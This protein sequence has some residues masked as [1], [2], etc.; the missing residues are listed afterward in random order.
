M[1]NNYINR[2]LSWLEF[3]RRVLF[4]AYNH[5]NPLMERL[6]FLGISGSNLD[7]FFMV[8]VAGLKGQVDGDIYIQ[9]I[10]GMIPAGA[11]AWAGELNRDIS[12][13]LDTEG[14]YVYQCDPH[15]MMAMIGVIQV[16]EA[17]NMNQIKEASKNLK[18]SFIMNAERIDTY[19]S[20]L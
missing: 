6:N 4:E 9:T 14:V 19:L 1:Q 13:T 15:V 7:E 16:G 17:V 8:R 10:D 3:N 20:Q 18:P 5:R 11:N 2:E 12:V